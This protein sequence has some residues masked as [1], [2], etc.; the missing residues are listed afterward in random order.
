MEPSLYHY[1]D[2]DAREIDLLIAFDGRLHPIEVKKAS[3]VRIEDA[4]AFGTLR[5]RG[6]RM[7]D[8]AVVALCPERLPLD[9]T[10]EAVPV[11][12]L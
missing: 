2:K 6:V 4:A 3:A 5:R 12:W 10:T 1:R 11:G 7:G 9:R 8:G